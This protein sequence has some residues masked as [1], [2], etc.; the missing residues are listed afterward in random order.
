MKKPNQGEI[1]LLLSNRSGLAKAEIANGLNIHP[2]HL[3]KLYRSEI[4]TSKIQ[5]SAAVLFGVDESVFDSGLYPD[6]PEVRA[7]YVAE[8]A[9]GVYDR[10]LR[11]DSLT[12]AE[13]MRYLEEKDK[14]HY[15]ERA[16]LLGII[17]NLTKP[18]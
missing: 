12:A 4:L 5:K 13:V 9:A 17:E 18:K 1:L 6:V 2:G 14:R 7:E 10:E 15:E 3:S 16:R 11:L 8:R